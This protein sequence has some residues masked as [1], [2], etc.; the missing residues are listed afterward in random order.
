[1]LASSIVALCLTLSL[2]RTPAAGVQFANA[3]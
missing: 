1:M 3:E 2:R